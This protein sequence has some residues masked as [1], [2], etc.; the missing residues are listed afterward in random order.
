MLLRI[1]L[2]TLVYPQKSPQSTKEEILDKSKR[3]LDCIFT[4]LL[5]PVLE[6][7]GTRRLLLTFHHFLLDNIKSLRSAWNNKVICYIP[8]RVWVKTLL[9]SHLIIITR[10]LYYRTSN[11]LNLLKHTRMNPTPRI[12]RLHNIK[13]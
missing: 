11:V 8:R 7:V 2:K 12:K 5:E 9:T 13:I 1:T 6:K 3:A 10:W 4:L